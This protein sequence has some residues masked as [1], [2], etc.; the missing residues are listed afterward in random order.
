M[1]NKPNIII[2]IIITIITIIIIIIIIITIIIIIIFTS[3]LRLPS[4]AEY[5]S[6]AATAQRLGELQQAAQASLDVPFSLDG[7]LQYILRS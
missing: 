3:S 7:K 5:L 2:I 6:A 4:H 1:E